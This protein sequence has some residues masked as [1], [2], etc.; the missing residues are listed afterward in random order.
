MTHQLHLI[1]DTNGFTVEESCNGMRRNLMIHVHEIGKAR[2][3]M[4]T[5]ATY[6]KPKLV[7]WMNAHGFEPWFDVTGPKTQTPYP[8]T[9]DTRTLSYDD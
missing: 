6:S 3:L 5:L 9:L 1:I 8:I 2:C 7:Q 4:Q